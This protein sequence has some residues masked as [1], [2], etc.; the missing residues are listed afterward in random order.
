MMMMMMRGG[1]GGGSQSN[2]MDSHSEFSLPLSHTSIHHRPAQQVNT[3]KRERKGEKKIG[4][5]A[6]L[7][8][9]SQ[10]FYTYLLVERECELFGSSHRAS[11]QMSSR[12]SGTTATMLRTKEQVEHQLEAMLEASTS[13]AFARHRL[14]TQRKRRHIRSSR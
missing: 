1:G 7:F 13:R 4:D 3:R 6:S 2:P 12:R 5:V 9:F 8:V 11:A 10:F 14:D